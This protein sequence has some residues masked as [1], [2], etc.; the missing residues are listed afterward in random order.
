MNVRHSLWEYQIRFSL[1]ECAIPSDKTYHLPDWSQT[2]VDKPI[3]APTAEHILRRSPKRK[4]SR[5]RSV[6]PSRTLY[7]DYSQAYTRITSGATGEKHDL[8][9]MPSPPPGQQTMDNPFQNLNPTCKDLPRIPH[10]MTRPGPLSPN[11][12]EQ[13]FNQATEA[14]AMQGEPERPI[15]ALLP[16]PV[17][18]VT[19]P[20]SMRNAVPFPNFRFY[21]AFQVGSNINCDSLVCEKASMAPPLPLVRCDRPCIEGRLL[22][23]K[24]G[25]LAPTSSTVTLMPSVHFHHPEDVQSRGRTASFSR[26]GQSPAEPYPPMPQQVPLH[27]CSSDMDA[28][29]RHSNKNDTGAPFKKGTYSSSALSYNLPMEI[30]RTYNEVVTLDEALGLAQKSTGFFCDLSQAEMNILQKTKQN[31]SEDEIVGRCDNN[32]EAPAASISMQNYSRAGHSQNAS[33]T[34][35]SDPGSLQVMRGSESFRESHDVQR[36]GFPGLP[37]GHAAHSASVASEVDSQ[38]GE[39]GIWETVGDFSNHSE[40][41][42]QSTI[43]KTESGSSIAD[44][45]SDSTSVLSATNSAVG[46]AKRSPEVPWDPLALIRN[47]RSLTDSSIPTLPAPKMTRPARRSSSFGHYRHP[48]PLPASHI[49]PLVSAE[50]APKPSITDPFANPA[51]EIN[52]KGIFA[53]DVSDPMSLRK[54]AQ[55]EHCPLSVKFPNQSRQPLPNPQLL[56]PYTPRAL[57][58]QGDPLLER[59]SED[60]INPI[61]RLGAKR[62]TSRPLHEPKHNSTATQGTSWYA[63]QVQAA[64]PYRDPFGDSNLTEVV[65]VNNNG[66]G[67]RTTAAVTCPCFQAYTQR[68][69]PI[70]ISPGDIS[71]EYVVP[72]QSAYCALHHRREFPHEPTLYLKRSHP[73]AGSKIPLQRETGK[74]LIRY[75]AFVPVIGWFCLALVATCQ[76]GSENLIRRATKGEVKDWHWR[77][78]E[79]AKK[80]ATRVGIFCILLFLALC[81]VTICVTLVKR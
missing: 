6:T 81:V 57:H 52:E 50:I 67:N 66:S 15:S 37:V 63:M 55:P 31:N 30:Q 68:G 69:S 21:P 1:E 44:M 78:R 4:K 75:F 14:G 2:T 61:S 51:Y 77:E 64:G 11:A 41:Q 34:Q 49:R 26:I 60:L 25:P 42:Q 28:V 56:S 74:K 54:I 27:H 53:D 9:K 7:R 24:D 80:Y 58:G 46:L 79:M 22:K 45:S 38:D 17:A 76:P 33:N 70:K 40:P 10:Y 12:A 36:Q 72:F 5:K 23:T 20:P 59:P 35:L 43:R 65:M 71:M 29:G 47:R 62:T 19:P 18:A 32:K 48:L 73:I 8:E 39:G 16:P 13:I 3:M